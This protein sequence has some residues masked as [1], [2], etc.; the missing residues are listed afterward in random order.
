MSIELDGKT[1]HIFKTKAMIEERMK[2]VAAEM[3]E[4]YKNEKDG[5][6][7]IGILN[8]AF[9]FL[10]DM[11]RHLNFKIQVDFLRTS[12]YTN[13]KQTDSVNVFA[14]LKYEVTGRK[15]IIFEDIIDTGKSM[16]KVVEFLKEMKP[17]S[18][19]ICSLIGFST[20]EYSTEITSRLT[21]LFESNDKFYFGY[22]FDDNELYRNLPNIYYF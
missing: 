8:G 7:C 9:I 3:N 22:G 15:V 20:K 16:L 12:S 1:A 13:N 2:E 14:D 19:D 21:F 10:A 4:K 11:V 5:V 6:I 18:I 17:A